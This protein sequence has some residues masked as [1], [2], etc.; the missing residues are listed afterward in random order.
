MCLVLEGSSSPTLPASLPWSGISRPP[1]PHL[2]THPP[3]PRPPPGPPSGRRLWRQVWR[4][5]WRH[6]TAGD[7]EVHHAC[8]RLPAP[9][10]TL[11][12]HKGNTDAARSLEFPPD[13]GPRAIGHSG[14]SPLD[15]RVPSAKCY[16]E[17]RTQVP[18]EGT[19]ARR[20][21]GPHALE[22]AGAPCGCSVRCRGAEAT[23]GRS[24][25]REPRTHLLTGRG[26]P[27]GDGNPGAIRQPET[28]G[29]SWWA[30]MSRRRRGAPHA[31]HRSRTTTPWQPTSS[32]STD[33]PGLSKS[34][35]PPRTEHFTRARPSSKRLLP[36]THCACS[37]AFISSSQLPGGVGTAIRPFD[38]PGKRGTAGGV[39]CPTSPS[40]WV[41]A[42][43]QQ[44]S[45]EW[46]HRLP[47]P[48]PAACPDF[49][50]PGRPPAG[51]WRAC[52]PPRCRPISPVPLAPAELPAS[53]AALAA[54]PAWRPGTTLPA[55]GC[56][57]PS[58]R[59]N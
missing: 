17:Q 10:A 29:D 19:H 57:W 47:S 50:Q 21:P 28:Q 42:R 41:A 30:S 13:N 46:A 9:G 51:S 56:T 22:P 53:R 12:A 8:L 44:S 48:L 1:N 36:F 34:A 25:S 3:H 24:R 11:W 43:G 54:G 38:R 45:P 18:P 35:W 14:K 49:L 59:S 31:E 6:P 20:D 4:K 2:P 26:H 40:Y 15:I 58:G 32:L 7:Q 39:S 55:S 37:R 5:V 23:D 33:A 27:K 16:R 52:S